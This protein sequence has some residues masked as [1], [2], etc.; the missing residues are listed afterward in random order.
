MD[1][2]I[3][4]CRG[5]PGGLHRLATLRNISPLPLET[6]V[7]IFAVLI[8]SK[9]RK[10]EKHS[11]FISIGSF[12]ISSSYGLIIIARLKNRRHTLYHGSPAVASRLNANEI[13]VISPACLVLMYMY[14]T[15]CWI[16]STGLSFKGGSVGK[17]ILFMSCTL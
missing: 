17:L 13:I 4:K 15:T 1:R 9:V 12:P 3:K 8:T 5:Y 10:I 14:Y 11:T 7:H 2:Y 16:R 6:L